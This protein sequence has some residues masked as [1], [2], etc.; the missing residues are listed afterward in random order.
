MKT[1]NVKKIDEIPPAPVWYCLALMPFLIVAYPI[2]FIASVLY[3][4]TVIGWA[5]GWFIMRR[6]ENLTTA[7]K[8]KDAAPP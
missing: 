4:C 5:C 1:D 7:R 8:K 3:E 6:L 2:G